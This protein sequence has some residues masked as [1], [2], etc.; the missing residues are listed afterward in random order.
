ME[1]EA[2]DRTYHYDYYLADGI[3]PK[4]ATFVKPIIS[5]KG[6]KELQ[7]HNAQ[8]AARKDVERA[9]GTLQTQFIIVRGPARFWDLKNLWYIMTACVIVHNMIIENEHGQNLDY[10]FYDLMGQPFQPRRI[11]DCIS[12]FLKVHHEVR[13][14]DIHDDLQKDLMEKWWTWNDRQ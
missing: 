2:N 10:T 3:Y 9:F 14:V 4:W 1:F 5:P 8:A 7:F 13:D 11:V 6:K 12:R